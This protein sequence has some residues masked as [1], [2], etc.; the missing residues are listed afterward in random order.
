MAKGAT[1]LQFHCKIH[2]IQC[3]ALRFFFSRCSH[4]M[5]KILKKDFFSKFFIFFF[6]HIVSLHFILNSLSN[7][8]CHFHIYRS[9][10][11][12][13]FIH[14]TYRT[15]NGIEWW[16]SVRFWALGAIF[17][18]PICLYVSMHTQTSYTL[19]HAVDVCFHM[20]YERKKKKFDA[21]RVVHIWTISLRERQKKRV[22]RER[23]QYK[24]TWYS[25]WNRVWQAKY[26][27]SLVVLFSSLRK[28][29]IQF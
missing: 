21:C 4:S 25:Y 19:S 18:R 7:F 16:F 12:C 2:T 22:R 10:F 24:L 8:S 28:R 15:Y 17:E 23:E 9:V 13:I 11:D 3:G 20:N 26:A 6:L 1:I 29:C 5:G 27:L 14:R